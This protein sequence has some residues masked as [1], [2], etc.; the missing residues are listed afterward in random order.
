MREKNDYYPTSPEILEV[1]MEKEKFAGNIFEPAC[2]DGELSQVLINKGRKVDSS[3]LIDRG[4]GKCGQDFLK[5]N[6]KKYDNII[7]NP[8]Y[9]LST[10]FILKAKEVAKKKIAFLLYTT[11]LEAQGR[12]EMFQDKRFGLKVVYQFSE[13]I[14]LYPGKIKTKGDINGMKAFAW[15]IWEKGY[16]EKPTIEWIAPRTKFLITEKYVRN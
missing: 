5:Y 8:P 7:T 10:Q 4:F 15:F 2:G 12:Y 11:F 14:T 16:K 3:D 1:L 13:R 6:G 9:K